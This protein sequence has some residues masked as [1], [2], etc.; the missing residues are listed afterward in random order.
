MEDLRPDAAA[1]DDP[2]AVAHDGARLI[3]TRDPDLN[4]PCSE[5]L[6]TLLYLIV[7]HEAVRYLRTG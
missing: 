5:A 3:L 6:R 7:R 2:L 1:H 4:P